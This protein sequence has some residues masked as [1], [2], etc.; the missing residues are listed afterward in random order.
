M[1]GKSSLEMAREYEARLQHYL[2]HATALPSRGGKLNVSAVASACGFDRQVLYKNKT[3]RAMIERAVR[4][5]GLMGIEDSTGDGAGAASSEA[6]V[7]M[8]KLRAEQRRVTLLEKRLSEM[9]ARNAALRARL[10]RH[11]MVEDD[12]IAAGRRSRPHLTNS[13]FGDDS[14]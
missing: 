5:K 8:A 3:A 12:L 10:H 1:T 13:L 7:P 9:I 4:D 2:A 6:M 14:E 11:A